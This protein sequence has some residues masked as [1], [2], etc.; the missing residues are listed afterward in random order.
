[1]YLPLVIDLATIATI[2][3]IMLATL[4]PFGFRFVFVHLSLG[5]FLQLID[6]QVMAGSVAEVSLMMVITVA[7][8]FGH[9]LVL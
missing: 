2:G 4:L 7:K 6:P 1:M 3:I 8:H 5:D 9:L